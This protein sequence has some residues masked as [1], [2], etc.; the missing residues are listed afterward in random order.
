[1]IGKRH[2]KR[3][4]QTLVLILIAMPLIV[5]SL[6]VTSMWA[7][8]AAHAQPGLQITDQIVGTG[9]EATPHSLVTVHYTGWLMDGKKFDSSVDRNEP[10]TFSLGRGDVIPGWDQGVQGM[11]VGGKRELIIPPQLAYGERGYPGAIPP[12]ATLK[13]DVEL[14]DVK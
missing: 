4:L 5:T 7:P 10:F 6:I 11:R 1:M 12:N 8:V 14:L 13:F 9:Q 3:L 2:M